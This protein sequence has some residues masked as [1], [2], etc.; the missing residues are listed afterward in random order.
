MAE[1]D[2][3]LEVEGL[4]KVYR[5]ARSG[6][7]E[8]IAD[9]TF[10]AARGEFV[11]LVG[12]SG[13]GKTTLLRCLSGLDRPSS[14]GV[15]VDG[16]A[17]N[18]V[19]KS[20]SVVFQ[21]YTRSLFPWLSV[22]RNVEFGLR[23]LDRRE[24]TARVDDALGHVGLAE[25]G[26]HYPWQLSG[27]MQQ[28]VAI[29]RA[30]ASRPGFLLMDEPFA[31]VDAQT[32]AQLESM[33]LDLWREFRWTVLL[34]THDIDEAIFLAD[35]VLVLSRRPSRVLREVPVPLDRPRDQIET[36][37]RPEFQQYR[38]EIISLIGATA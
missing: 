8:A 19:Q 38:K 27:G 30:I 35:R 13:C 18:G 23:G 34:V 17:V 36:R 25:F 1:R 6:T 16:A 5:A 32:R 9:L 20:L 22:R 12:P 3:I 2:T 31:S 29:A 11:V 4:R 24:R 33:V 26:D 10:T 14:G 28:R 21:E 37:A 7:T 15:R